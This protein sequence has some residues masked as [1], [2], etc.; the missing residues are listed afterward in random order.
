MK[1]LK[2]IISLLVVAVML[3]SCDF[4]RSMLNKPTSKDIEKMRVDAERTKQAAEEAKR[5]AEQ[6]A[7]A[8]AEAQKKLEE[9]TMKQNRLPKERYYLIYGSF[10][11]ENNAEKLYEKAKGMGLTPIRI[12]F[13]NGFDVVAFEAFDNIREAYD[14]M[15]FMLSQEGTPDDIWVYDT[16]QGLHEN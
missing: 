8:L 16:H 14:R 13:K 1:R 6:D 10:R 2:I 5:K 15:N 7:I 12:K 4:F 11:V 9:E 3:S